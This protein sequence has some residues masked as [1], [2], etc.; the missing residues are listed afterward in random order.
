MLTVLDTT[1]CSSAAAI[2]VAAAPP[3]PTL[4]VTD[5]TRTVATGKITITSSTTGLVFSL[6]GG[7]FALY[8]AGGYTVNPGLHSIIAQNVV[9]CTSSINTTVAAQPLPSSSSTIQRC[10]LLMCHL[11]G[12]A[13]QLVQE[14]HTVTLTNAAGCDSLATLNLTISNGTL[15]DTPV[16]ACG[17]F[18]WN[19]TG[20][21]YTTS[22]THD[23]L[24]PNGPCVDTVRLNLTISNGTLTDTPG[25]SLRIVY[26]EP[27]RSE[28]YNEWHS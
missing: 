7:A 22:G 26:L 2:T 5:P 27:Y 3:T 13:L 20:V 25:N 12:I 6:D 11:Y 28:L 19:R 4:N 15:T 16:T 17:S 10:V 21:N 23:F 14:D 1:G 24:I 18:T 9:N 8:P